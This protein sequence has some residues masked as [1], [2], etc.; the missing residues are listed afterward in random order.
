MSLES[1]VF[2][3]KRFET[4]AEPT[5]KAP[6]EKRAAWIDPD[7]LRDL[8]PRPLVP[9]ARPEMTADNIKTAAS[10]LTERYTEIME[11]ID[12]SWANESSRSIKVADA[13]D[14]FSKDFKWIPSDH[15]AVSRI[16]DLFKPKAAKSG[17]LAVAFNPKQSE[18]SVLDAKGCVHVISVTGKVNRVQFSMPFVD[19]KRAY[20]LCYAADGLDIFVGGQDG[21]FQT[22]NSLVQTAQVSKL[23]SE[24]SD[25][26][27]IS[28]SP[29]N[30]ILVML[31]QNRVHFVNRKSC[32]I[33][34]SIP[35]SDDIKCGSF[36]DDGLFYVAAGKAGRGLIFETD[37]Y[38]AINRFQEPEMQFIHSLTI[39]RNLAAI[40][41]EAGVVHIFEFSSLKTQNPTPLFSKLNL[42][43]LIDT[44]Q[45]NHT[46]ELL[47]FGS[48]GK[49][50]A[51]RVMH[52]ASK[53][54][55]SNWP[56]QNTPISFL[57]GAAF[58]GSSKWLALGNDKGIC[59]LWELPFYQVKLDDM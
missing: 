50:D 31:T 56:T 24:K 16:S 9:E 49:K 32:Q 7:D 47:V 42:T 8:I 20:C 30:N 23:L 35:T 17:V 55:F 36:T 33:L 5:K 34:K 29:L 27:V 28:A 52:V 19:R 13:S 22:I 15:L 26:R 4:D 48:S 51:M 2:G 41:T 46:G 53:K 1:I 6:E 59:T 38:S 54:V 11:N 25:I 45:F 44:L 14:I 21:T 43:T 57:R 12:V 58:E 3:G 39:S 40:G 18:A 10:R 37:T